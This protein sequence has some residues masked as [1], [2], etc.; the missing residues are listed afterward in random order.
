MWCL[1]PCLRSHLEAAIKQQGEVVGL[2]VSV[3][4]TVYSHSQ[5]EFFLFF[6]FCCWMEVGKQILNY[7]PVT[8]ALIIVW[9][10]G[11]FCVWLRAANCDSWGQCAILQ[12][13][14]LILNLHVALNHREQCLLLVFSLIS[15]LSCVCCHDFQPDWNRPKRDSH[16][17]LLRLIWLRTETGHTDLLYHFFFFF[18]LRSQ[19]FGFPNLSNA[20]ALG[21]LAGSAG[22]LL[23]PH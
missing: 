10:S 21:L 2:L 15:S 23:L 20:D 22:I 4:V 11:G 8:Y 12:C 7:C 3:L 1:R 18:F 6:C 14:A 5:Y 17:L 9:Q 16:G 19:Y 13:C